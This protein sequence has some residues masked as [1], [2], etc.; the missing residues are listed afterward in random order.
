MQVDIRDYG[1]AA[2][3]L[4]D[5]GVASIEL[6]TDNPAKHTCLHAHG[7]RITNQLSLRPAAVATS[8]GATAGKSNPVHSNGCEPQVA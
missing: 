3:I 2:H 7:I 6:L 8:S 4:R 5:L 1:V